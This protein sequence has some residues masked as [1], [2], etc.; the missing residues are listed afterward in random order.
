[1]NL[2]PAMLA[3]LGAIVAL[4][5]LVKPNSRLLSG[6]SAGAGWLG[7]LVAGVGLQAGTG[8]PSG[9][10]AISGYVAMSG[11]SAMLGM[12][13]CGSL[14]VAPLAPAEGSRIPTVASGVLALVGGAYA[15]S[16]GE[17][18]TGVWM[19]GTVLI[20]AH[21]AA[22]AAALALLAG[23]AASSVLRDLAAARRLTL[24]GVVVLWLAWPLAELAHWRFLGAPGLGSPLEWWSVGAHLVAS[25]LAI[26]AFQPADTDSGRRFVRL[27]PSL[28]FLLVIMALVVPLST[29]HLPGLT[30][31]L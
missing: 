31:P 20:G 5:T 8:N 6:A 7:L 15:L 13:A 22:L 3:I 18:P 27:L 2:V 23:G 1:M 17:V 10:D 21:W 28:V 4:A 19:G 29:N 9:L 11:L 14:A 12:A 24:R 30:L 26:A 16:V 25:G